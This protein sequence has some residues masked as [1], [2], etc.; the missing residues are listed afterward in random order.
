KMYRVLLFV[1]LLS[2]GTWAD[3][4]VDCM[5]DEVEGTWYLY[6][7]PRLYDNSIN[8]TN[9]QS[10]VTRIKVNLQYPNIVTDQ[11][12]N[13]GHW[14]MIYNEGFEIT[15]NG[16]TYFAYF[17]YTEMLGEVTSDCGKTFSYWS[18]D[19]TLRHWACFYGRKQNAKSPKV[20]H[21]PFYNI[22]EAN[23]VLTRETL[24]EFVDRINAAQTSWT[25]RVYEEHIGMTHHQMLQLSGGKKSWLRRRVRPAKTSLTLKQSTAALP[26]SF[27]WRNVSGVNYVSPVRN[28]GKCG[29]CYA[30]SSMGMLEA[31]LRIQTNNTMKIVLSPEDIISCSILS[32]GCDGGFPYLVAGKYAH[33]FGVVSERCNPYNVTPGECIRRDC[34]KHYTATYGYVGGYYGACNEE[35][36][37][38][39]LVQRGP[40]SISFEVYND[41]FNYASGIYQ[42]TEITSFNPFQEVNHAVLLVGY[43]ENE[44]TGQKFWIV[45]NSWGEGWGE[46]GYF[47]IV[48][49]IDNCAIESTAVAVIPIP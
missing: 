13:K 8:C 38:L 2:A 1:A 41:F 11:Y 21:D 30:F 28:Q 12:G 18:H 6:E 16:R 34:L 26:K 27:D 29:S 17:Y 14:T 44:T 36:M 24:T 35:R 19:V 22:S 32:Q 45:K 7:G 31:R 23:Q 20:H 37:M 48:R 10:P 25:A 15:V 49:G 46:N 47:R 39:E 33:E 42:H 3:I 5:Y 9:F 40:I 43:G 4:P